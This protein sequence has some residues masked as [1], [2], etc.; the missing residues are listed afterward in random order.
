M[1][2][3]N[4]GY[5]WDVQRKAYYFVASKNSRRIYNFDDPTAFDD[6]GEEEGVH[7]EDKHHIRDHQIS[8]KKII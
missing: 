5:F 1:T 2:L 4:L 3:T 8:M 7:M 6:E